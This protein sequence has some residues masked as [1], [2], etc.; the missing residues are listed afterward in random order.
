MRAWLGSTIL[1]ATL[2]LGTF[3]A[4]A[5][6]KPKAEVMHWWTSGGEAAAVKVFAELVPVFPPVSTCDARAV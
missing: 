2:I 3:P 6:D 1:G 4:L 5:Q